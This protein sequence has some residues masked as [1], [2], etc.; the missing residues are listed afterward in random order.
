MKDTITTRADLLATL[1]PPWPEDPFPALRQTLAEAKTKLVVL[2]DD[3]T[4]TQTVH[5]MPV[6]TTWSVACLEAELK[7]AGPGFFILTNS[8][9]LMAPAAEALSREIGVN[10]GQAVASSGVSVS[11]ISRSD[12]TLR[13]HFPGEVDALMEAMGTPHLPRIIVP[14]F[15][16]GRR[17]TSNDIH[18]VAEGNQLIPAAQTPYA[19]D[20]AF[21]YRHSNLRDWVVEKTGGAVSSDQLTSVTIEDIRTG[22]PDR[23]AERLQSLSSNSC[24]IVNALEYRDLEVFVAG[25][26]AVE[27]QGR[28][29]VFRSAA[30]F[31]RVRAGIA[32]RNLLS[33]AELTTDTGNGGL[34][35]VG[36]YV[37]KTSA[38]LAALGRQDKVVEIP[39]KVQD[40]LDKIRRPVAIAAAI[41]A[42][43][44]ALEKG[45]DVVLF[46]SR[47]LV[48]GADA[49]SS[50]N[51]GRRVSNSLIA[52]VQ[53]IGCQPRYL[54]AKGGIT[55]SDVATKGL[56]VRR[57]MV[58]GQVL[59]GVPAWRLGPETRWPGMAYIVFPG[60]V[61][62]DDALADIRQR[63]SL[64]TES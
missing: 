22:G 2:D 20:A 40:L 24:C 54:V 19:R 36:S 15:F 41:A 37:P 35:V 9:S 29:F 56:G 6:L 4:G 1:P 8:R 5:G 45:Q 47:D 7:N 43:N 16:E 53:D 32:P 28:Q 23:V 26:L 38:Q 17:L 50:L 51:I 42:A 13:G 64:T 33:R 62:D 60:N 52:I 18:Y 12:S 25:L 11:V 39:V 59:P 58:M 3:P 27:A 63:L 57:A 48:T 21:G 30:S 34:F 61:G 44:R 49:R 55:S 46:T 14:C 10:L 31:V